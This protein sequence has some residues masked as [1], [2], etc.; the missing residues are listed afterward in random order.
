MSR[1]WGERG[2]A[3][4]EFA[5]V[6]PLVV[7]V[8][9]ALTDYGIWYTDSVSLKHGTREGARQGAVGDFPGCEGEPGPAPATACITRARISPLAATALV[10][11]TTQGGW[12]EGNQLTVC[13]MFQEQG[14]SGFTPMPEGGWLRSRVRTRIERDNTAGG[15]ITHTDPAPEGS[16]PLDWSWC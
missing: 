10:K 9:L 3:A 5:L 15:E 4:V 16:P 7:M 12:E 13:A 2:A 11:V 1:P 14:I 6:I 8:V